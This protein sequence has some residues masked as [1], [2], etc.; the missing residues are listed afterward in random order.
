MSEREGISREMF[1]HLDEHL[2]S[3]LKKQ[4]QLPVLKEVLHCLAD[5]AY[6]R[7][8]IEAISIGDRAFKTLN[9]SSHVPQR[10]IS[11]MLKPDIGD[12]PTRFLDALDDIG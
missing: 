12:K 6:I 4:I 3:S 5:W 7:L 9:G 11:D 1:K 2:C 8:R 10:E